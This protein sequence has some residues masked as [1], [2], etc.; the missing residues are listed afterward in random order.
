MY[1][2]IK[3]LGKLAFMV[4]I[5]LIICGVISGAM[6]ADFEKNAVETTAYITTIEEGGMLD[7]GGYKVNLRY[8][9]EEGKRIDGTISSG[10]LGESFRKLEAEAEAAGMDII[11]YVD[12]IQTSSKIIPVCYNKEV[13]KSVKYVDYKNDGNDFYT[14]GA[15][16]CIGAAVVL[17]I[18]SVLKK[19]REERAA[20]KRLE[21][22]QA[23]QAQKQGR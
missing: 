18:N 17:I 16:F 12:N 14:W 19:K 3:K 21:K 9:T 11:D 1:T 23:K 20:E 22:K 15:V 6:L 7:N 8:T 10:N 4:G 2:L 5:A 13:P